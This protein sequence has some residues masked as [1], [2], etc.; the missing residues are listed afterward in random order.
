M[1]L[2]TV[3]KALLFSGVI[4][5]NS[6]N[7]VESDSAKDE[8]AKPEVS[9]D[10]ETPKESSFFT[11]EDLSYTPVSNFPIYL[12]RGFDSLTQEFMGMALDPNSVKAKADTVTIAKTGYVFIE[13]SLSLHNFFNEIISSFPGETKFSPSPSLKFL[14]PNVEGRNISI[15]V[16]TVIRHHEAELTSAELSNYSKQ[17]LNPTNLWQFP[18]LY[19]NSY[20]SHA[21]L[22][23]YQIKFYRIEPYS[24]NPA[25][26]EE[27]KKALFIK[28]KDLYK[29]EVTDREKLFMENTLKETIS[30][31]SYQT[32]VPVPNLNFIAN[33]ETFMA[34]DTSF[35]SYYQNP[36]LG[37]HTLAGKYSSYDLI[38]K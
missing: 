2:C 21:L 18:D 14:S 29:Q 34:A 6:C 33:D 28:Y 31:F 30:L 19:G 7:V 27:L 12:G 9:I 32:S 3:K 8:S 37:L 10:I 4:L 25:S 17:T 20:I 24:S 16:V 26:R 38:N 15:A 11:T 5:L 1:K 22:G 35:Y 13:D 36:T 23:G